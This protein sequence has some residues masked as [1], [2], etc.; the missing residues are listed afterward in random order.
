MQAICTFRI[1]ECLQG[2]GSVIVK[3]RTPC[4]ECGHELWS[5]VRAA[6]SLRIMVHFDDDES[7]DTYAEHAQDCPGCGVR[8]DRVLTRD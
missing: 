8:L 3:M 5:E 4:E 2:V 6:G 7:C 1:I